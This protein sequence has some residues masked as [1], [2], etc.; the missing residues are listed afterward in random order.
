MIDKITPEMINKR[1]ESGKFRSIRI[2]ENTLLGIWNYRPNENVDGWEIIKTA[3][4]VNADNFNVKIGEKVC[5]E[6]IKDEI[7]KMLGY[8][9][10]LYRNGVMEWMI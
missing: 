6:N 5:I 7:W 2:S 10:F 3:S 8:E 9:L 4:C 1:F